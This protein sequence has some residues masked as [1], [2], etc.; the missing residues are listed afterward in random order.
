[1]SFPH[2]EGLNR[3]IGQPSG[4]EANQVPGWAAAGKSS[5]SSKDRP[6]RTDRLVFM[7]RA[8]SP[9]EAPPLDEWSVPH[10]GPPRNAH[11]TTKM[12]TKNTKKHKKRKKM[13]L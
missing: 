4:E 6:I 1:M 8:T 12:A 9:E 10:N 3:V 7:T 11:S 13:F 5:H 2:G